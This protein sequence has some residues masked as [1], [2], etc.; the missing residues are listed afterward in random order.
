M[1]IEDETYLL[2]ELIETV[3]WERYGFKIAGTASNAEDA[4]LIYREH[5]PDLIVTDIC[6][7][8]GDG[9]ELIEKCTPAAAII[10]TGHDLFN[11]ARRALRLG[12]ADF[13]LKPI[14][15][16]ELYAAL[17]RVQ[18]KLA[19]P[20]EPRKGQHGVSREK[21]AT[22][23][24]D[25]IRRNY[26]KNISLSE[27]AKELGLSESYLSR[28]I[29]EFRKRTFVDILT[30]YRLDIAAELLRDQ[31]LRIGEVA[32]LCGFRDH[33]YFTRIFKKKFG[34]S[35]SRYSSKN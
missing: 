23:A 7:P 20:A 4:L 17:R 25:F 9:L 10:I 35:P 29:K 22:A 5:R 19:G 12:A 3:A 28:T 15:D 34:I 33:A 13:L 14:E 16:D 32:E 21:H 2:R 27:A 30:A 26:K 6:L 24:E 1:I 11:Y 31:R 8:G 18:V